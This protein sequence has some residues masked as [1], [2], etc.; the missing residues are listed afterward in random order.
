[1]QITPIFSP[2]INICSYS[3]SS[4]QFQAHPD[5]YRFN[6]TQSCYFRR[7]AVVLAS[8]GYED[9]EEVFKKVFGLAENKLKNLLI[10]GIGNSQEP[11][12][13]LASIKS[14]LKEKPLNKNLGLYTVDLQSKPSEDNIWQHAFYDGCYE[15]NIEPRF[16]LDS[17]VKDRRIFRK[18]EKI[19][20]SYESL[21]T[22]LY[23]LNQKREQTNENLY[24]RVNDEI[25]NFLKNTYNNPEKSKWDSPIQEAILEYPDKTF[26]IISA[27]NVLP[28]IISEDE[29][30]KTINRIRRTLKTGGYFI[31][32]PYEPP[33]WMRRAGVF[34]SL[35]EIKKGIYQKPY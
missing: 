3:K 1:M 22:Y 10:I 30:L 7:G 31:T 4:P 32:D 26:D 5:F 6:S 23:L 2:K 29:I 35:K 24:Y 33:Y 17:F 15:D 34:D 13:Y 16:A 8:R 19:E 12:S 28:Y 27:N 11:F 25:L 21:Y 18:P 20:A 14:I 9:V